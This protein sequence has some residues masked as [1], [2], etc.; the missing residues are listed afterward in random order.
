MENMRKEYI[1]SQAAELMNDEAFCV[2]L[3]AC[4]APSKV[5]D[6]FARHGIAITE[7]EVNAFK[8][9]GDA[10][11]KNMAEGELDM[12]QLEDVNGGSKFWRGVAVAAGG[13]ILGGG[14]GVA[15]GLFPGFTPAAYKIGVGYSIVGAAWIMQG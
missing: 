8:A 6:L 4:D 5:C 10:A 13:V 2:E 7:E 14:M 3:M 11:L 12:D 1:R 9:E 15:C